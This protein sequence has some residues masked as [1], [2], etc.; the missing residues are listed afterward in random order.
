MTVLL[1]YLSVIS[2]ENMQIEGFW[3]YLF[4]GVFE[5]ATIRYAV[6]KIFDPLLFGRGWVWLRLLDGDGAGFSAL[7]A[8]AEAAQGKTGHSLLRVHKGL[9]HKGAALT[10][11]VV[12]IT[13]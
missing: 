7:S 9:P 8:A 12:P 11:V 5:A 10:V 1:P 2:R 3:Y 4:L 13:R 6:A